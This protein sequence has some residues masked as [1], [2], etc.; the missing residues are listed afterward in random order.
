MSLYSE[1]SWAGP[2][3]YGQTFTAHHFHHCAARDEHLRL[4]RA[5]RMATRSIRRAVRSVRHG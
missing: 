5:R 4:E 3:F 2:N 1:L